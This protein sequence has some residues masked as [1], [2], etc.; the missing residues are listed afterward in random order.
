MKTDTPT[1]KEIEWQ[2][3]AQDLSVVLR[4]I[5]TFVEGTDG[6]TL[7]SGRT[8]NQD[9]THV[10]TADRRLDRAG[11]SVRLRRTRRSTTDAG[12]NQSTRDAARSSTSTSRT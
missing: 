11:Y 6:I 10:D 2:L 5:E 8:I 4:W 3:D 12:A 9:D 1:G 7:T